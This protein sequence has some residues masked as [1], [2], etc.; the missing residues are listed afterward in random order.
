[1]NLK[2]LAVSAIALSLAGGVALG[3]S[4]NSSSSTGGANSDPAPSMMNDSAKM[5]PFFTD[6]G[7]MKMRSDDE[8]SAS[9]K[10]M[11]AEDQAAMKKECQMAENGA[12]NK[13]LCDKI[14]AM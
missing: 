9:F 1:M 4:N 8:I 12:K 10:A 7:M 11:S 6:S 14:G 13:G 3:Q 5:A 2:I